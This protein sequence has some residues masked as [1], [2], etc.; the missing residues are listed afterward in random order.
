MNR[1]FVSIWFPYLLPQWYFKKHPALQ[2]KP[3]VITFAHGGRLLVKAADCLAKKNGIYTGISLADAR[4]FCTGLNT[5]EYET[6]MEQKLLHAMALYMLRFTPVTSADAEDGLL[7]EATGC[8][9]LWKNEQ[10]Y[11]ACIQQ[12]FAELGYTVQVALAP[13]IGMAWALARYLPGTVLLQATDIQKLLPKIPVAALRIDAG[14]V[15]KLQ[16]AGLYHLHLL[17]P[18]SFTALRRR[19]GK[20]LISRLQQF[21]GEA[22]EW[23]DPVE[24]PATFFEQLHCLEPVYTATAIEIAIQQLLDTLCARLQKEQKGLRVATLCCYRIDHKKVAISIGTGQPSANPVHLFKLFQ[25]KIETIAPG[26]GI[27]LFTLTA[28]KFQ[29][30]ASVQDAL[31][32]NAK[33]LMSQ[34]LSELIDRV[35]LKLPGIS[36]YQYSPKEH[37]W[38]ERSFETTHDIQTQLQNEWTPTRPRPLHLLQAPQL[39]QVT[40]PVPDYPPLNFRYKGQLH[41]IVKADGPERIEPEWWIAEGFHRDYYY[42][43]DDKGRRYW[44]YRAGH[45]NGLRNEQWFLHGFFP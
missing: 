28:N 35:R 33:P 32:T 22:A 16:L 40:A 26:F 43:E 7:L 36:I 6:G 31:W 20:I 27:E 37:Y 38:P 19:F 4:A 23:I 24:P 34:Q 18:I 14:I 13:T 30:A 2:N 42:V 1:L 17:L 29:D 10:Q 8:C 44:L 11:I 21:W 15:S 5:I 9:H 45:Y 41:K 25:L 39:I 12:R 3:L